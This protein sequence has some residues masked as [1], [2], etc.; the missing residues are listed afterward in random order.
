MTEKDFA[1]KTL[2]VAEAV[3]AECAQA[4]VE[5]A[6][7]GAMALA[8]HK[9]PRATEDFDLATNVNPF[10]QLAAIAAALRTRG[11]EV[12]LVTPDAEDPL[13]GVLNITGSDFGLVQVVNYEN[14]FSGRPTPGLAA[15]QRATA[16]GLGSS[17]LRVV[18]LPDLV[19]LKLYAGG[20][21][22]RADITELLA[23]NAPVDF[24][25]IRD[26]CAPCRLGP[27]LESLL[28][29]LGIGT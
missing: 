4:G 26:A 13:G 10:R 11:Y 6:V 19:A 27:E 16:G 2:A 14:P 25:A 29:A 12:E 8:A 22:S 17:T 1:D 5:C 28:S 20:P 23:R 24:Q 3:A 9:Y 21:K 7:I 18:T 15:I